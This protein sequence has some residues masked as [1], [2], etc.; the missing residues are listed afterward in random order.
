[1]ILFLLFLTEAF[2][3][4]DIEVIITGFTIC[5]DPFSYLQLKFNGKYN[6]ISNY[7]DFGLKNSNLE[8]LGIQS[9][10]TV[11]NMTSL[12]F[13]NINNLISPPVNTIFF[14]YRYSNSYVALIQK[15]LFNKN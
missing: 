2:I 12:I 9:D 15:L 6:F 7:F 1:M 5:F 14:I 11:V 13:F 3:P 8:K 4:K 10:S